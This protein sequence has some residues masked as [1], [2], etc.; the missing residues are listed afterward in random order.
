MLSCFIY[1]HLKEKQ[2]FKSIFGHLA[3]TALL[4][5]CVAGNLTS[6]AQPAGEQS[7]SGT[8]VYFTS[9]S[10]PYV[11]LGQVPPKAE[12]ETVFLST[13]AN[14]LKTNSNITLTNQPEQAD[15]TVKLECGGIVQCSTLMLDFYSPEG[16]FLSRLK[17]PGHKNPFVKANPEAYVPSIAQGLASQLQAIQQQGR[18]G[19]YIQGK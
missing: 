12:D 1:L 10:F 3:L 13:L 7:N 15:I 16:Q 4:V 5:L 2:M 8:T 14:T 11:G 9:L 17:L 19:A 18:Y 6:Q